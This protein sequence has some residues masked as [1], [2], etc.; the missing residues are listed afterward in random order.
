[1]WPFTRDRV[2]DRVVGP[3]EV[4]LRSSPLLAVSNPLVAAYL[5]YHLPNDSG[6][7][8]NEV[9]ALGF[10]A[11]W[12]ACSLV[13]G[14]I[15]TLPIRCIREVSSTGTREVIPSWIENPAGP[16]G[17]DSLTRLEWSER[18]VWHMILH[19]DAFLLHRYNGAGALAGLQPV[20]PGQVSVEWDYERPGDKCY[21]V[22]L[23]DGTTLELDATNLTQVMGPSLD[24]LRGVSLIAVAR[25]SLGA[26]IAGDRAAARMFRSGAL[27]SGLVTADEELDADDALR[28]RE[29]LNAQ[30]LGVE[31]A[32]GFV[33]I[34]RKLKV[35]PWTMTAEDAQFLESRK[36]SVEEV[37][38][39]TG[40]PPHLL[41]QT[42][43]QTSW[44]TGVEEQNRGMRQFTLSPWT[45]RIEQK[46]TDL[47][48]RGQR[49]EFD[50][51]ALER[52]APE[53]LTAILV[54]QVD[55]GLI[56]PNE[57]RRQLNLPPV[58]DGDALRVP[59]AAQTPATTPT[60]ANDVAG[61]LLSFQEAS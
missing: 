59:G 40:V 11:V 29:E 19:G 60:N 17:P 10:S 44:G 61:Q 33:L 27:M 43:K 6:E 46:L 25:N 1:M 5:G 4:E 22:T 20:Y 57:A 52:P 8:V 39:W 37:S 14:T 51:T 30:A 7:P 58:A 3:D 32:G 49:V 28:V 16:P 9:T 42:D 12:R 50:Y 56:T 18:V 53:K 2:V 31:N 24:G 36:F 15:G 47:I 48:P 35:Q 45:T 38:R 23:N 55:A 13:G 26:A 41:M 21:R 54:Q 34:N